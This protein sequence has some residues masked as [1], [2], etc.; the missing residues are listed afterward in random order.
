N[1]SRGVFKINIPSPECYG[2]AWAR[3]LPKLE[4][5]ESIMVRAFRAKG[6]QDDFPLLG[7]IWIDARFGVGGR[8]RLE[9]IAIEKVD[10]N[11]TINPGIPQH[12]TQTAVYEAVDAS[13]LQ[14]LG[15]QLVL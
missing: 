2:F 7:G 4:E 9:K 8:K 5:D 11:Q 3:A 13:R 1:A 6:F 10:L 12:G 14:T 15:F